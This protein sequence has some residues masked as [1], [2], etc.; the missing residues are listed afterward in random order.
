MSMKPTTSKPGPLIER[1]AAGDWVEVRRILLEPDER[2][3][4]LPPDTAD[5][6]LLMWVKG[7]AQAEGVVGEEVTIETMSG[8]LVSG[9]LS[10]VNP[11]YAHTFGRPI[12]ELTHVGRD[13]R[14]RLADYHAAET[15]GPG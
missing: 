6:P 8:R 2:A 12:P 14:A 13:L 10:A 15:E 11:G 3:P 7:F 4:N 5:K 9:R 1:C